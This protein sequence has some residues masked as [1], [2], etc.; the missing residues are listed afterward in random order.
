MDHSHH[1]ALWR[2]FPKTLP[3]FEKRFPDEEAARAY[4]ALLRW[5]G[6]EPPRVCRRHFGLSQAAILAG[7]SWFA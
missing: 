1:D 4:F 7:S 2:E 3:E 6:S 5:N